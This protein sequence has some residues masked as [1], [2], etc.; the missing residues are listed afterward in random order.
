MS[1]TAEAILLTSNPDSTDMLSPQN[2]LWAIYATGTSNV[3]IQPDSFLGIEMRGEAR[4]SDY[5]VEQGA[6]DTYNKV[7]VPREIRLKLACSNDAMARG[8]FLEQLESMKESIDIYDIS[9]P[10]QLYQSFTLTHFDYSRRSTNGVS[11]IVADCWFEEVR[12]TGSATYSQNNSSSVQSNSPSANDPVDSGTVS[13]DDLQPSQAT[14]V[15]NP[16][17]VQ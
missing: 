15:G 10:D 17:S 8:D 5:P 11:L 3:A 12:Q 6:F 9:T 2:S 16:P 1:A 4:I 13:P 7:Q 14:A